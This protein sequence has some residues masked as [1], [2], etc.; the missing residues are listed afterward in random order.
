MLL[1]LRS[2]QIDSSYLGTISFLSFRNGIILF[3]LC[4]SYDLPNLDQNRHLST[5]P[6]LSRLVSGLGRMCCNALGEA[7]CATAEI[8]ARQQNSQ[9]C[10]GGIDDVW[11]D[12]LCLVMEFK[13]WPA[14][15]SVGSHPPHTLRSVLYV[16]ILYIMP[17]VYYTYIMSHIIYQGEIFHS[18]VLTSILL[19][20]PRP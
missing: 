5:F 17:H 20:I 7:L 15:P 8:M 16:I 3:I 13:T 14:S 19:T 18:Y 12:L 10:K 2:S 9:S 4:S 11:P 1:L 6:L